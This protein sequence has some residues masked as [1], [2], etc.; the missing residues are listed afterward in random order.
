MFDRNPVS[1]KGALR[2]VGKA[3][4]L[5]EDL[6]KMLSSET[7]VGEVFALLP[8]SHDCAL[9]MPTCSII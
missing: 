5:S 3:L 9:M 6:T 8:K 7:R 2:D 1:A 4:G